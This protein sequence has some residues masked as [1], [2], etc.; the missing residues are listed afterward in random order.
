MKWSAEI[1]DKVNI[2]LVLTADMSAKQEKATPN[3]K[4]G[5]KPEVPDKGQ[6]QNSVTA[7]KKVLEY[8]TA[9]ADLKERAKKAVNP[10]E[11]MK[12]LQQS[13][14]KE[15]AAHGESKM[16]K[17][18][19]SGPW[20]GA[21]AGGGI[22]GGVGIGLGAVVGTLVGGLVSVPTVGLGGLIGAGVGSLHGPFIKFGGGGKKDGEQSVSEQEVHAQAVKEAEALDQAVEKGASTVPEPP[23]PEDEEDES[24]SIVSGQVETMSA[25]KKKPRKLQVRSG[26][27]VRPTPEK[28]KPRKLEVRSGSERTE[29]D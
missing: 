21:A 9:A 6:L 23:T 7:A 24:R 12:L 15:V 22:G 10:K 5:Q 26:N 27:E 20:Q 18:M 17:R 3:G 8:Q 13:Y 4:S 11:R 14:E 16:A 19:Q 1:L 2:N 29:N 28:K 25:P